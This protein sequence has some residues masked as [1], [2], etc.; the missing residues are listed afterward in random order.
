MTER[1]GFWV[2]D[3]SLLPSQLIAVIKLIKAFLQ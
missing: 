3:V 2:F 1:T